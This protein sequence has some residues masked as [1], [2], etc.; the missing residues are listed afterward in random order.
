M[1]SKM[2]IDDLL[3]LSALVGSDPLLV[4]ASSGNTSIKIDNTLWIKASGKWLAHATRE[5][6]LVPVVLA[7]LRE[8]L[9][10][11]TEFSG[12]GGWVNGSYLR[13]SIETAMH[14]VLPQ[15]VVIHV[16]S[17]NTISWAVR[18]DGPERL[19]ERLAGL[20]WSWIP[21]VSSGLPLA[22]AIEAAIEMRPGTDVFVL[23]NHGLVVCGADCDAARELL[24]TVERRLAV[25][26]R[27]N[28]EWDTGFLAQFGTQSRWNLPESADLHTL[29]T[30]AVSRRILAGGV[31]YPCQAMFLGTKVE[32]MPDCEFL[33]DGVEEFEH[34][35]GI[36]AFGIV[37]GRGVVTNSRLTASQR[38][39]LNGLLQVVQRIDGA[40]PIRYLSD[41]E[42]LNLLNEDA[43][44]YQLCTERNAVPRMQATER[45]APVA[46]KSSLVIQQDQGPLVHGRAS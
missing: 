24:D 18:L 30:D 23:A 32:S 12:T 35:R 45:V 20:K 3:R 19:A 4:Q 17:V 27:T 2:E 11:C 28:S 16:H 6:T 9:R 33:P 15:R 44:N 10:T 46:E 21:Y 8:N 14:A 31:L 26:A 43:H 13:A 29:A 7:E 36:P 22:R 1:S 40:A 39:V 41:S 38:C 37:E 34:E 5:E 42:V 25:Q